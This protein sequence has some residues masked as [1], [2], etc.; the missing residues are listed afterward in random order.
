M[1]SID[2]ALRNL[3]H[4]Y[5]QMVNGHVRDCEQAA[6]GLLGPAI[7]M[8]EREQ[9]GVGCICAEGPKLYPHPGDE[10][11]HAREG[12]LRC[13]RWLTKSQLRRP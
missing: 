5:E 1:K 7:E 2:L 3:R 13:N 11:F 6:R 8:I 4:L 10:T 12:C 9:T